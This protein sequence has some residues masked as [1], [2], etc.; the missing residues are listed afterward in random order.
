MRLT[1]PFHKRF[2][3]WP[4]LVV[5]TASLVLVQE[6]DTPICHEGIRTRDGMV[7]AANRAEAS[8]YLLSP[9]RRTRSLLRDEKDRKCHQH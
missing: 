7:N 1:I 8:G 4:E 9:K 6:K 2:E 3:I 5:I